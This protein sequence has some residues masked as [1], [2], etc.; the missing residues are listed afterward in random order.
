MANAAPSTKHKLIDKANTLIVGYVGA[1]A[2]ILVFSIVA[3]KT[4]VSQAAYQNRVIGAKRTAVNQLKS[5]IAATNNLKTSYDAFVSGS[6]NV[7]GGSPSGSGSQDGNNAKIV[8]DALPS[9]YDFPGLTTDLE[10][11]LSSQSGVQIDSISGTDDE[12]AQSSNQSSSNPQPSSIPFSVAVNGD[13][14]G[15]QSVVSAFERSIR[16]MQ[17]ETLSISGSNAGKQGL[18]MTV[19]AQT[20]YQPA[21][22]FNISTKVVK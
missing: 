21:K 11:L 22:S 4:L 14:N 7:I 5:D 9:A 2:F 20:Y 12:I 17:I 1:A 3:T 16:P 13:Y 19:T 10:S 18:T 8:L 6:P 15:I